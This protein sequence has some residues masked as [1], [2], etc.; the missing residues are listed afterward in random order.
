[1]SGWLVVMRT[2]SYYVQEMMFMSIFLRLSTAA[3]SR[4]PSFIDGSAMPVQNTRSTGLLCGRPVAL[5]LS[6]YQT[7]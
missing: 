1:M 5:A 2:Y 4:Y 3:S 7:T 6:I